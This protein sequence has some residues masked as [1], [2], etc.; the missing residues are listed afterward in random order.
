MDSKIKCLNLAVFVLANPTN[1]TETGTAYTWRTTSKPPGPII[2]IDQSETLSHS[3]V[4]FITLFLGGAQLCCV[5]YQPRQPA[6]I[7]CQ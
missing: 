3:Q 6:R 7:L 2:M 1:K 5:F 4:Q